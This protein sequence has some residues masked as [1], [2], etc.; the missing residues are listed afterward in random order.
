M[1]ADITN[2]EIEAQRTAYN[3]RYEREITNYAI[4]QLDRDDHYLKLPNIAEKGI[5]NVSEAER[6]VILS[7]IDPLLKPLVGAKFTL[8]G[9]DEGMFELE[10]ESFVSD[11]ESGVFFCG[12]LPYGTYYLEQTQ[13]PDGF[14]TPSH[15]FVFQVKAEGVLGFKRGVDGF[16]ATNTITEATDDIYKIP[17]PATT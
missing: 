4:F 6:P 10:D 3:T 16:A 1:L 13:T 17:T 7:N 5:M 2:E 12:L 11:H 9:V 8:H 14:Q 15:Y